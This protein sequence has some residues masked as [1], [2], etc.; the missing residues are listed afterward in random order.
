M[1]VGFVDHEMKP[2]LFV[3][4]KRAPTAGPVAPSSQT[5]LVVSG[6]H[7]PMRVTSLTTPYTT[8]GSASTTSD[9]SDFVPFFM[10]A[11]FSEQGYLLQDARRIAGSSTGGRVTTSASCS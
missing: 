9:T 8:S 10:R 7:S 6:L 3:P 11:I 5:H 1:T 4:L 2:R